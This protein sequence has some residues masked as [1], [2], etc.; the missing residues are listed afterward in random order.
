MTQISQGSATA[1]L[2]SRSVGALSRTETKR[3][4]QAVAHKSPLEQYPIQHSVPE[5]YRSFLSRLRKLADE[6][7]APCLLSPRDR[8]MQPDA[9]ASCVWSRPRTCASSI[10][11]DGQQG[12]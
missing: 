1:L 4:R 8:P 6:V 10:C 5:Y 9:R 2:L 3:S 12:D 7:P 11:R